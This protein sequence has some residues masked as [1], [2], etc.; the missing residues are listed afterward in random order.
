MQVRKEDLAFLISFQAGGCHIPC[1]AA[2]GAG[3][4]RSAVPGWGAA[5]AGSPAGWGRPR[6]PWPRQRLAP[7]EPLHW[8]PP[9]GLGDSSQ[10][11][12]CFSPWVP[13]GSSPVRSHRLLPPC[14]IGRGTQTWSRGTGSAKEPHAKP[15]KTGGFGKSTHCPSSPPLS[16]ALDTNTVTY[17]YQEPKGARQGKSA[18]GKQNRSRKEATGTRQDTKIPLGK[19]TAAARGIAA[20]TRLLSEHGQKTRETGQAGSSAGRFTDGQATAAEPPAH[21]SAC[22]E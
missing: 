20:G 18:V 13:K 14:T 8:D 9:A 6:F 5:A 4:Q 15:W 7:T 11:H 12:A 2:S 1:S 16:P 3:S 17:N 10:E 19:P 21:G 22:T